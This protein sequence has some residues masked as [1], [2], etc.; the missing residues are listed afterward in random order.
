MCLGGFHGNQ[1][2]IGYSH[3][4]GYAEIISTYSREFGTKASVVV[5]WKTHTTATVPSGVTGHL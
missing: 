4:G 5:G 1:K 3:A 2:S